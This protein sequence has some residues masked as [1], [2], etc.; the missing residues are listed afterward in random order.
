M[1]KYS[2]KFNQ[3]DSEFFW[4]SVKGIIYIIACIVSL[5]LVWLMKMIIETG[6]KEMT[7]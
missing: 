6:V 1:G 7:W 3:D 5:G 4:N 2:D